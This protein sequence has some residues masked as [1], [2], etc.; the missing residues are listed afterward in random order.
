M[1]DTNERNGLERVSSCIKHLGDTSRAYYCAT[2]PE[3]VEMN[4]SLKAGHCVDPDNGI[5]F[6]AI[7]TGI[8][9]SVVTRIDLIA[10]GCLRFVRP[11]R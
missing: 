9:A 6:C 4:D 1:S 5:Q 7:A 11:R 10:D 3:L 2:R 8:A